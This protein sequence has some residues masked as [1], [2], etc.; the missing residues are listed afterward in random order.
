M[1]T[2]TKCATEKDE[3]EF[4]KDNQKHD[5]L[6]SSCREC[7]KAR[8][9]A[10]SHSPEGVMWVKAY[11]QTAAYKAKKSRW[12]K[13]DLGRE[14]N[15]RNNEKHI[16]RHPEH[17]HCRQE[18]MKAVMRGD[19]PPARELLCTLADKD[20][21]GVM[22]YHHYKGYAPEHALDVMPVC[23]FHH[24]ILDR[25]THHGQKVGL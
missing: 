22:E 20:C 23:N 24:R 7:I 11:R 17:K 9:I 18:V 16:Q 10:R 15:K 19:I 13:S 2:C 5:G 4:Y 12:Y 3:T 21:K 25:A 14:T 6:S 8:V 1:K